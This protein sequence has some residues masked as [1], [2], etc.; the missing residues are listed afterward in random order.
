MYHEADYAIN[1][2]VADKKMSLW[3]V[4]AVGR[5][6]GQTPFVFTIQM[7]DLFL[8]NRA[9]DRMILSNC[10]LGLKKHFACGFSWSVFD[11][12]GNKVDIS[13]FEE[14]INNG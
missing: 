1:E 4:K 2:Y 7:P 8:D 9:F 13:K 12:D 14:F 6:V 10:M 11:D 3:T 5:I